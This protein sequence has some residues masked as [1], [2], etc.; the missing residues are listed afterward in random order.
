L[1]RLGIFIYLSMEEIMKP[2]TTTLTVRLPVS[3]KKSLGD[4][5]S[6]SGIRRSVLARRWILQRLEARDAKSTPTAD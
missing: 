1:L 3:A 2:K 5:A 4:L 6:A